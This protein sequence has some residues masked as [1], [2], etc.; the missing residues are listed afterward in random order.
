[1]E[2]IAMNSTQVCLQKIHPLSSPVRGRL[3]RV[4]SGLALCLPL[5]GAAHAVAQPAL[6][7]PAPLSTVVKIGPNDD[8]QQMSQL[9][10]LVSNSVARLTGW[11]FQ[12][13][14]GNPS[15]ITKKDYLELIQSYP[16]ESYYFTTAKSPGAYEAVPVLAAFWKASGDP[17]Y[18]DALAK[19]VTNYTTAIDAETAAQANSPNPP[20]LSTYWRS[21]YVWVYLGL[22]E[23][24]GIPEG[25]RMMKTFASSLAHRAEVWLI[26]PF[27]GAFN[28]AF[29]AAFWYDVAL[30]YGTPPTNAPALQAYTD[31]IWRET[32]AFHD[33]TEDDSW[34]TAGD[35]ITL[36][37]WYQIRGAA[38][39]TNPHTAALWLDFAE[40]VAND[41]TVMAHGDG[42]HPG[43]YFTG[44]MLNELVGTAMRH[45]RYRWL[46]HRAFWNGRG[47][48]QQ[49]NSGIG[50]ANQ[51]YLA[52]AYLF[53]DESV[54]AQAPAAGVTK[55][56][57]Q[58]RDITPNQERLSGGRWFWGTAQR[59]PSKV[60]FRAGGQETDATLM[61]QAA[62][63][64]GHGHPD[65]G[66]I[67]HY[68]SDHAYYLSFGANR[69][70]RFQEEHNVFTLR[71]PGQNVQ[72]LWEPGPYAA[73]YTTE[74][75]SV[76]VLGQTSDGSYARVH[77]QEY[78]G[79]TDTVAQTW[80][81]M[82]AAP[83][84][85][86]AQ[87]PEQAIG[88]RNWPA[89]LD[90]SV[91]FANHRFTVVRD[92]IAFTAQADALMGQ[93]WTF[94]QMGLPGTHWVNVWTPKELN[95]WFGQTVGQD[96]LA[97][98]HTAAKDLLIWFAPQ[99]DAMLEVERLNR[100]RF[101]LSYDQNTGEIV[102]KDP[103]PLHVNLPMRAWYHRQGTWSPGSTQAFTTVLLPH[104]P[105]VSALELA[106]TIETVVNTPDYT[107]VR[108]LDLTDDSVR[109]VLINTSGG[110]V[111]VG[112]F[113]TDAESGIVTYQHGKAAHFS[114]WHATKLAYAGHPIASAKAPTDVD[115]AWAPPFDVKDEL[116][117]PWM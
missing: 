6:M 20:E 86:A 28:M 113:E 90:R 65:S 46:A 34:Y 50:H 54:A 57:R 52:L 53:A 89:R 110:M 83:A 44:V 66:E 48:I 88:Y 74:H 16:G 82:L 80:Q 93:N 68:G 22:R 77:I 9:A 102:E 64:G 38:W 92:R 99:A 14:T 17:K 33:T 112:P 23:L 61:L 37:A 26:A 71:Q 104:D 100:Q 18:L 1:L 45:G 78:P 43:S 56:I 101:V 29:F 25:A 106:K 30:H 97:P 95:G 98:V 11:P 21:D 73:A 42:A 5:L 69:L 116:G 13:P 55:T 51:L 36:H 62:P 7:P 60:V 41:G 94:G 72:P 19:A 49:L 63:V 81:A 8:P 109:L 75:T 35:L 3:R 85:S 115:V 103:S 76:P 117:L 59:D 12:L 107:A 84:F 39:N 10:P 27:Q 105:T 67:L 70:D 114:A 4:I 58:H 31:S 108:V 15:L 32:S 87:C 40:Q 47:R 79:T 111:K 2:I 96:N 24:A 91:V